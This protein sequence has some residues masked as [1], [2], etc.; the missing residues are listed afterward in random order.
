M[1]KNC[2]CLRESEEEKQVSLS[3]PLPPN[4]TMGLSSRDDLRTE[5][6]KLDVDMSDLIKLQSCLRGYLSRQEVKILNF[7]SPPKI[8][9]SE[10]KDSNESPE[11]QRMKIK[12]ISPSSIPDYSNYTTRTVEAQ[13]GQFSYTEMFNDSCT[14]VRLGPVEME[15]GAI[16]IG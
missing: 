4:F 1:E 7:A 10:L 14:T 3:K 2:S 8:L 12:E 5:F 6:H 16:Y 9:F 15:N 13:L 11:Q